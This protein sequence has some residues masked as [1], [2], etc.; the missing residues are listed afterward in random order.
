MKKTL[1]CIALFMVAYCKSNIS[2]AQNIT[3]PF[4]ETFD[5]NTSVSY[6]DWEL[7]VNNPTTI[8]HVQPVS[9]Y[10]IDSGSI[11]INLWDAGS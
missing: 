5:T 6:S 4:L 2:V 11:M 9:A 3:L 10:G 7:N 8:V 1:F